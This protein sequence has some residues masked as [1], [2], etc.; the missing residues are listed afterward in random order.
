MEPIR[1]RIPICPHG[2]V[3]KIDP[4]F[5]VA[6]EK[7]EERC[8]QTLEYTS[9]FR[10][11]EC[12]LRAGGVKNSAHLRGKAVDIRADTSSE[13]FQILR[14]AFSMNFRRIGVGRTII[15]IDMDCDLPQD[16]VWIY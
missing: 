3:E 15:H 11:K 6:L 4:L 10:C 14:H 13:R 12:N 7:L 2:T 8:D 16:V 9:G 5:L 1:S